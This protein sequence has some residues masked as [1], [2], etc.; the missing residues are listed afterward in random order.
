MSV[1]IQSTVSP[2]FWLI[3]SA[4]MPSGTLIFC[5]MLL[6]EKDIVLESFAKNAPLPLMPVAR[7]R[8]GS[9]AKS[10]LQGSLRRFLSPVV[11]AFSS[12]G[13]RYA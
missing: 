1:L 9:V 3:V 11:S 6:N 5:T 13:S 7:T 10:G 12:A 4:L 2:S 8:S